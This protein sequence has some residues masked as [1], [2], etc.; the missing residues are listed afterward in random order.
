MLARAAL[1]TCA[2]H[3]SA[4]KADGEVLID[5]SGNTASAAR[6]GGWL[7]RE[8]IRGGK[9]EDCSSRTRSGDVMRG[10]SIGCQA[11]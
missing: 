4:K 2:D 9:A 1:G 7:G 3:H 8:S 10:T 11:T 5:T 6:D